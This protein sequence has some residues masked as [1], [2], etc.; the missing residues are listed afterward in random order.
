MERLIVSRQDMEEIITSARRELTG[1]PSRNA[2][3]AKE[4]NEAF[5]AFDTA[6]AETVQYL[7]RLDQNKPRNKRKEDQLSVLWRRAA[8]AVRPFD[9]NLSDRCFLKGQGWLSPKLWSDPEFINARLGIRD[10]RN[11]LRQM[12]RTQP[13]QEIPEWF[14]MAGFAFAVATFISLFALL[15]MPDITPA[16]RVIFNAWLAFCVAASGAFLGGQAVA[17]GNLALPI[18]KDSPIKFSAYGG[19]AIFIVVFLILFA[20]HH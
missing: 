12:N 14:P 8:N 19:I 20:A 16:K 10:M 3:R 15:M 7:D 4:F 13:R 18:L 11:A 6:L 9:S 1:P 5:K 17:S 2:Q